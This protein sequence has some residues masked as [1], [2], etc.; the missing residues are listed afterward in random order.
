METE[1]VDSQ[2]RRV[3]I[4]QG[5]YVG[6]R[7]FAKPLQA[8]V[9]YGWKSLLANDISG[10]MVFRAACDTN[11]DAARASLTYLATRMPQVQTVLN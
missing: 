11:C 4:W 3:L 9:W 5:Y 2:N 7:W 6:Q 8:Q 1:L 10:V